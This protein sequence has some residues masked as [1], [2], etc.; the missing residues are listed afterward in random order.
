MF[1]GERSLNVTGSW[2]EGVPLRA[3]SLEIRVLGPLEVIV[4]GTPLRVDTRKALAIVALLAVEGRPYAR[5]ELAAM[6]WPESDD[7]SA[8]GAFRRTLSV[9][10]SALG[11]RWVCADRATVALA[12]D[13]DVT[14]DLATLDAA[15]ARGDRRGL[16]EAAAL[17]RGPFLAGF[18]LRDSPDFDDWRATRAVSV[19]RRVVDVLERLTLAA[20]PE[21]D[22]TAAPSAASRPAELDPLDEPARRRL[23]AILAA[24]G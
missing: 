15:V 7:E 4:D 14:I 6:F 11:D 19:E 18:S 9:L 23:M 16:D 24:S 3:M 8:R 17:A 12:M 22:S 20:E 10:R 5:D 2:D 21:G 1:C 13:G